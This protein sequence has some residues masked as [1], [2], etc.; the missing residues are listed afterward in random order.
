MGLF[1]HYLQPFTQNFSVTPPPTLYVSSHT[2]YTTEWPQSLHVR[3]ENHCLWTQRSHCVDSPSL[4]PI[5][6]SSSSWAAAAPHIQMVPIADWAFVSLDQTRPRWLL[7]LLL[8][9]QIGFESKD[10][11]GI[12][13]HATRQQSQDIQASM[14]LALER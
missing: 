9:Q 6:S 4:L 2:W 7:T 10:W 1:G 12:S 8:V 11:K 5:R 13:M 14:L 3:P